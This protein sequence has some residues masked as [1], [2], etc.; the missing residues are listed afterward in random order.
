[1]KTWCPYGVDTLIKLYQIDMRGSFWS[2]LNPRFGRHCPRQTLMP[3]LMEVSW[4]SPLKPGKENHGKE[5]HGQS[6]AWIRSENCFFLQL[7]SQEERFPKQ[8]ISKRPTNPS[9]LTESTDAVSFFSFFRC[10]LNFVVF[11]PIPMLPKLL[12]HF[13]A[14]EAT[15]L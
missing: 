4:K 14:Q 12:E 5:N 8:T 1:M 9:E 15:Q 3:Q 7:P 6:T 11:L 2:N 10:S 13:A